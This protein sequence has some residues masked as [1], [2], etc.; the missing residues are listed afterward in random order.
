MPQHF[1]PMWAP[2]P[3]RPRIPRFV[4]ILVLIIVV[5]VFLLICGD[6]IL[7]ELQGRPWWNR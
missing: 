2:D 6:I 5:A 1:Q 3:I 7:Y 4:R